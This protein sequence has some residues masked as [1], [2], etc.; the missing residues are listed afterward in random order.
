MKFVYL[1]ALV[2]L[3]LIDH[4]LC[5]FELDSCCFGRNSISSL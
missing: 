1:V 2:L 3:S 4:Q 5:C